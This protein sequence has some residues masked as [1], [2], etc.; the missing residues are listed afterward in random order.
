MKRSVNTIP[1]NQW[2]VWTKLTPSGKP[3]EGK[4]FTDL[5][6]AEEYAVEIGGV[7][8]FIGEVYGAF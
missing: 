2:V 5:A 6:D 8:E 1:F 4:L 7:L 3:L